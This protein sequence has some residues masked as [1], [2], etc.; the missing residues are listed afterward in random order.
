MAIIKHESSKNARYTDVLE[1]YTKKHVKDKT[2]GLYEPVLDEL[3]HMQERENY[4][5]TYIN[6]HGNTE[7]PNHWA[8]ACIRTNLVFQENQEYDDV[9]IHQYIIS[10]PEADRSQMTMEDLMTEGRAFAA[11]FFQGYDVLLAVHRDTDNDHI[12]I[13]VNSVRAENCEEQDWMRVDADGAVLPGATRAGNKHHDDARFI[14][15]CQDWLLDYTR[16]HNLTLEDNNAKAAEHKANRFDGRC[17]EWAEV[18]RSAARDSRNL[19]QLS[20]KL[21]KENNIRLVRRGRTISIIPPGRKKPVRL[22][23]LGMTNEDLYRLLDNGRYTESGNLPPEQEQEMHQDEERKYIQWLRL[24]REKNALKTEDTIAICQALIQDKLHAEGRLY[25]DADFRELDYLLK[26]AAYVERDLQ[27][28]ADKLD[29]LLD[30]WRQASD[31]DIPQAERRRHSS[32]VRWCGCDPDSSVELQDLRNERDI[33]RLEMEHIKSVREG[34]VQA[35]DKWHDHNDILLPE[36]ELQWTMSRKA[37]LQDQLMNCRASRKKL[38][39]IA[40]NC[41]RAAMKRINNFEQLAKADKFYRLREEKLQREKELAAQ[42]RAVQ[43][44]ERSARQNLRDSS[45]KSA[46]NAR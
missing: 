15:H 16:K 24:R 41:Q 45:R 40:Y 31:P 19:E 27:T 28:E 3:G 25:T 9:K 38:E 12:H 8:S 37:Q 33:I 6:S 2:T 32:Y 46:E 17:R 1:Y 22:G 5:V 10:H 44:Q 39:Q 43:K 7:D 29:A 36:K 42:L 21:L 14:Q 18:I 34:L 23:T 30:R 13:S 4:A 26:K 11:Q 35:A 20:D